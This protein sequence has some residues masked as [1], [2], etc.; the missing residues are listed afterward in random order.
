MICIMCNWLSVRN[1]KVFNMIKRAWSNNSQ[2][3]SLQLDKIH[4]CSRN[5]QVKVVWNEWQMTRQCSAVWTI[6]WHLLQFSTDFWR[7]NVCCFQTKCVPR[8]P[9]LHLPSCDGGRKTVRTL[10]FLSLNIIPTV[11]Y[12]NI[13]GK[14]FQDPNSTS[15]DLN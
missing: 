14:L 1:F 8:D 11:P 7:P 3:N 10:R 13:R 4:L 6:F 5:V 12:N 15:R 2:D 9:S